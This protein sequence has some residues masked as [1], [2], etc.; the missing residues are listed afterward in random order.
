MGTKNDQ[1]VPVESCS[2]SYIRGEECFF[3]GKTKICLV[4]K[5]VS[6]M[7]HLSRPQTI[8]KTYVD[9][10]SSGLE[11]QKRSVSWVFAGRGKEQ[12]TNPIEDPLFNMKGQYT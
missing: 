3:N 2:I 11:A 9:N 12:E 8:L 7:L 1:E 10:M 6:T 4:R 5:N